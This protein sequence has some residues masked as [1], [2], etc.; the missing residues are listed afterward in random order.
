MTSRL[1]PD[2]VPGNDDNDIE[3]ARSG[4]GAASPR[5]LLE[6]SQLGTCE[7]VLPDAIRREQSAAHTNGG[8]ACTGGAAPH[9]SLQ[10]HDLE[11]GATGIFKTPPPKPVSTPFPTS[12]ARVAQVFHWL[13]G[14]GRIPVE[15]L[16]R[17]LSFVFAPFLRGTCA[18]PRLMGSGVELV[19]VCVGY[20]SESD[21][22]Q[23]EIIIEVANSK[24][25]FPQLRK[26]VYQVWGWR[27]V[28]SLKS[29]QG[30]GLYEVNGLRSAVVYSYS[31]TNA[32]TVP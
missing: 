13:Q 8:Q 12:L 31:T 27:F 5:F 30:F 4:S 18:R 7:Y 16:S 23:S 15:S 21:D 24:T 25:L 28:L 22:L 29:L 20:L 19:Y 17:V 11:Y 3:K 9:W 6:Q 14:S 26:A 10:D 1:Q 32:L 2:S